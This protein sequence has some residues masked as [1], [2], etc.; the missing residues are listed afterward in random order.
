MKKSNQTKTQ[1]GNRS[2]HQSTPPADPPIQKSNN[3][4]SLASSTPSAHPSIQESSN[5]SSFALVAPPVSSSEAIALIEARPL[6][7][8][9]A[10]PVPR[11]KHR[12]HG[13]VARLPRVQRDMVNRMLW[14]GIPYKNIIAAL[15]D[16][17]FG[18]SEKNI[19][20]W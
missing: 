14:N 6:A 9:P 19:S 17:G 8:V 20:N 3:P 12:R 11:R 7:P 10:Q 13:L 15:D 16:A 18:L 4:S 5:P 1:T 2:L